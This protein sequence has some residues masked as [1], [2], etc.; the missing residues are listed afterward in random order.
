M[1]EERREEEGGRRRRGDWKYR[2]E[3]CNLLVFM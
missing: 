1:S 3:S 2:V